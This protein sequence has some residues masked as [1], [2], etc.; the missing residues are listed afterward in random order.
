[1]S[2]QPPLPRDITESRTVE[3]MSLK[4]HD[5]DFEGAITI[6]LI[7]A[8]GYSRAFFADADQA[9]REMAEALARDDFEDRRT[10]PI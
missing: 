3:T 9:L 5:R 1:M 6:E 7:G 8:E 2:D 4:I 10:S